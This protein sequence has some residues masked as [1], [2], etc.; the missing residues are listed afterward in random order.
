MYELTPDDIARFWP[1]VKKSP[2]GCWLWIGGRNGKGKGYGAFSFGG[3]NHPAHRISYA[4]SKG[5]VPQ[6]LKVLHTCD[7][8]SCVNPDHLF[9][10]TTQDNSD[11][12]C[13]KGRQA[14]GK[15]HGWALHPE[16]APRGD[17]NGA[18]TRPDRLSRGDSH[19][20]RLHPEKALRGA[21]HGMAKLSEADVSNIRRR[22]MNGELR[23]HMAI[24]HGVHWRLIDKIVKRE[25]WKHV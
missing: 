16:L 20:S 6:R 10:G 3:K 25:L 14:K 13:Q 2:G 19:Y 17:R 24:E 11:D 5:Q 7:V 18:R 21:R 9:V 8:K 23:N 1:K 4:I 12:M 22:F 15:T